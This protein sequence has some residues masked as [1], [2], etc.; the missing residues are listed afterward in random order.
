MKKI[1]MMVATIIVTAV[2]AVVGTLWFTGR[3]NDIAKDYNSE[4]ITADDLETAEFVISQIDV[5][6]YPTVRVYFHLEDLDGNYLENIDYGSNNIKI[7]EANGSSTSAVIVQADEI[8]RKSISFV[9]DISGSMANNDKYVYAQSAINTL[10]DD[11]ETQ[12]DYAASLLAFNDTQNLLED[13][14]KDYTNLR[15][16]LAGVTPNGGTAFWDSLELAL[17]KANTQ[18]GQKCVIAATDGLDNSSRTTKEDVI[19]L[20][21]QL[22][23]PIYIIAF[24][25]TTASEMGVFAQNTGGDCF[26]IDDINNLKTVYQTIF[27]RQE[28]QMMFEFVSDGN[29]GETDRGMDLVLKVGDYKAETTIQYHKVSELYANV[30]TNDIIVSVEASSHLEEYY[31]STGHLYH[32]AENVLDGSYRTAWVENASGNGIGEWIQLNFDSN[33][34]INGLE[35]SN[36][37]K[38]SESL[39]EKNSR[40]KTI[41]LHFSDGSSQE[42]E[43]ADE[44]M[45]IQR[46]Q[47]ASPI[48]T[49]YIRIELVDMYSGTKYEDT[50]ITE[51]SVY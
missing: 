34:V 35:I 5:S 12:G 43:L 26:T 44:F 1:I 28:K 32:V 25:E 2:I 30:V 4:T 45:G 16:E 23:I 6:E 9:I 18:D 46:L 39:Y 27:T 48:V 21:K 19:A 33:H 24:D 10:L 11:M 42:F 51:L 41:R 38:K 3:D 17:I 14:S 15:S 7:T 29:T 47:F 13:F 20:S 22:Q 49:N 40:A 37:Y 50:C 36:G 31:K 8:K